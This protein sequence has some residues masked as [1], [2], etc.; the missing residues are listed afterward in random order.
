MPKITYDSA[1]GLVQE[2]GSGV[3]FNADS[4]SFSTLPTAAVQAVTTTSTVTTPGVYTIS[5]ST[6]TGILTVALPTAASV[7]GGTFVFRSTS[8][9]PHVLT[10]SQESQGT[11]VFAG[12]PGS[13]VA[14]VAA[15]GSRLTLATV[16]GSSVSLISD[17]KSFLVTG[18]SGSCT[19][20]GT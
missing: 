12:I 5:G 14:G 16:L 10:G 8:A 2:S 18:L 3:V 4:I 1:R 13:S 15:Q 20:A 7:P 6:G 19:I 11:K 9:D 17:G